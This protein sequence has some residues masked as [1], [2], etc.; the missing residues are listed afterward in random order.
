MQVCLFA[1]AVESDQALSACQSPRCPPPPTSLHL[2]IHL[3][4]PFISIVWSAVVSITTASSLSPPAQLLLFQCCCG[5]DRHSRSQRRVVFVP[6]ET[7]TTTTL[8]LLLLLLLLCDA[9]R[10]VDLTLQSYFD[11]AVDIIH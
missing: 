11:R 8:L 2:S 6:H 9:N 4:L 7:T 3:S 1:R 5:I 10:S